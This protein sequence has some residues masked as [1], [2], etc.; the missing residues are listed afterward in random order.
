MRKTLRFDDS[1]AG[2]DTYYNCGPATCQNIV[3]AASA[4]VVAESVF[5][6]ALGTTTNGTNHIGL[7]TGVLNQ[8]LPDA[9]YVTVQLPNDPPLVGQKAVLWDNIRRSIDAGYGVA[10]N[11][12]APPG[13]YPKG[14]L[15]SQSPSYGGGNI[16][17]YFMV[18]G[19]DDVARAVFIV[20]SGFWPRQYWITLDQ[21][22]SLIP[23]KGYSYSTAA[24][25]VEPLSD[26]EWREVLVKARF[27]ADQ[28]GPSLWGP[29]SSVGVAEGGREL[30]LRDGLARFLREWGRGGR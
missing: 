4:K 7:L 23:P 30:T 13:N 24:P 8:Y 6:R 21:L 14:V 3:W 20:D 9:K 15:G 1:L 28:F 2:Q 19:Y 5:A 26:V 22:A 29:E 10:V 17:H 18:A 16:Y 11:I 27:I 12:V 25:A